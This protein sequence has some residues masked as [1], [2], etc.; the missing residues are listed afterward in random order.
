[1]WT[2]PTYRVYQLCDSVNI[3]N[4][5]WQSKRTAPATMNKLM[6]IKMHVPIDKKL[7]LQSSAIQY[8]LPINKYGGRCS[9]SLFQKPKH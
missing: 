8:S 9:Y 1:M 2:V 7:C 6:D 5:E 3:M 4:K